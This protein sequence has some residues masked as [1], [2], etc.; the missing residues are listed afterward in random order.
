MSF[1]QVMGPDSFL[2]INS[3]PPL[4]S[5]LLRSMNLGSWPTFSLIGQHS[6]LSDHTIN[7][8]SNQPLSPNLIRPA[9]VKIVQ[10]RSIMVNN[11]QH[12]LTTIRISDNTIDSVANL[13]TPYYK[14]YMSGF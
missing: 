5:F 8:S 1:S 4:K 11:G 10:Q 6:R 2:I 14:V 3:L 12:R 7:R 9:T 13:D